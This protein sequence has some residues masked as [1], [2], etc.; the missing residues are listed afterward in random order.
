[1]IKDKGYCDEM[2]IHD[3]QLLQAFNEQMKFFNDLTPYPK[4]TPCDFHGKDTRSGRTTHIELKSRNTNLEQIRRWRTVFI[5]P[6]KYAYLVKIMQSGCTYNEIPLYINFVNDGVI[7]YNFNNRLN[8][9]L[10]PN[11]EIK[12]PILGVEHEGRIEL[13]IN[14]ATIYQKDKNGQY[15]QVQVFKDGNLKIISS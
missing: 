9:I 3:G 4:G 10:T 6:S 15:K 12:N 2:E 14:Q 1:M 7:I 13:S 8:V 5:E 11:V